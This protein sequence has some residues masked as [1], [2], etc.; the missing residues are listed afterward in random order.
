MN[1]LQSFT[2]EMGCLPIAGVVPDMK[3]ETEYYVK[4]QKIYKEKASADVIK[5]KRYLDAALQKTGHAPIDEDVI[6]RFCKYCAFIKIQ[7]F[8][9]LNAE[10]SSPIP[11]TIRIVNFDYRKHDD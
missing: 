2:K 10:Y 4:I 6:K 11:S 5:F 8:A 7:R 1:A 3:A 9:S